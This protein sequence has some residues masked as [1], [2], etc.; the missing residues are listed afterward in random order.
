MAAVRCRVAAASAL[1]LLLLLAASGTDAAS[2]QPSIVESEVRSISLVASGAGA[3]TA[4]LG[5]LT[6]FH[7]TLRCPLPNP[8]DPVD[9]WT[10]HRPPATPNKRAKNER[11]VMPVVKIAVAC[12]EYLIKRDF[13]A[14]FLVVQTNSQENGARS[15][16]HSESDRA[17][18]ARDS[19]LVFEDEKPTDSSNFDRLMD[20]ENQENLRLFAAQSKPSFD[21]SDESVDIGEPI[22]SDELSYVSDD[23]EEF[24]E[25]D[26]EAENEADNEVSLPDETPSDDSSQS[27]LVR[28]VKRI[29]RSLDS[30]W[31]G[32]Q[33]AEADRSNGTKHGK[34]K[35][36]ASAQDKPQKLKNKKK[37]QLTKEERQLR[38]EQKLAKDAAS[39]TQTTTTRQSGSG[40]HQKQPAAHNA[41]PAVGGKSSKLGGIRPK[42][43]YDT[44][45]D[46]EGSGFEGSGESPPG[47]D[48]WTFYK[49][50]ITL[51]EPFHSS[52]RDPRQNAEKLSHVNTLVK[53]LIDEALRTDFVVTA[54]RFDPYPSSNQLTLV[55]LEL[56]APKDFNL[57][58]MED[59]IRSQLES[60][61]YEL[62]PDG[63]SLVLADDTGVDADDL[64]K[65][66]VIL[67]PFPALSRDPVR[68]PARD[69]VRDPVRDP[70]R[71]DEGDEEE[72]DEED[73]DEDYATD[74]PIGGPNDVDDVEPTTV[75]A[76]FGDYDAEETQDLCRGDDKVRCGKTSVYICA[77]QWCDGRPDCPNGEDENAPECQKCEKDEFSCDGTRCVSLAKKCD[78]H[79]DCSDGQD[80]A[81]CPST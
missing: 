44:F 62:R 14:D 56:N 27:W 79:R 29:K 22:G 50:T 51:D 8:T 65:D 72:D 33:P 45:A 57:D 78:G 36:K 17:A 32:S 75:R 63:L 47:E 5:V 54:K 61:H 24:G 15:T 53:N 49:M 6:L 38:R 74:R 80:E 69:P 4:T 60:G 70:I 39:V 52:M 71:D 42:R 10:G 43:Q 16:A 20:M 48:T 35:K 59:R 7:I 23:V 2:K 26:N 30:L 46:S 21:H 58:E 25:D 3:W 67:E 19:D 1:L 31:S 40:V 77:V 11:V 76:R 13:G 73:E 66:E 55:T 81:D 12:S 18:S 37:A 68:G 41:I 9:E 28:N 64:G 34:Q